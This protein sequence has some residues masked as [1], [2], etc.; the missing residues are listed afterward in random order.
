NELKDSKALI[1][2]VRGNPGGFVNNAIN[3]ASLFIEQ[4]TVV[5]IRSRIPG[6]PKSPQYETETLKLTANALVTETTDSRQPGVTSRSSGERQPNMVGDRPVVILVNGNSA[7]ASEMFTGA[8]KDNGRATVVGT[9]TFGKG[10][11]QSSLRMPNGTQLHI[12]SLRYF[13]PNGTWLGDGGNTQSHGIEPDVV[14]ESAKNLE[15][16]EDSDN[17]LKQAIEILNLKIGGG[18]H[19]FFKPLGSC[20][21]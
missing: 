12:T 15:F 8:V 13:T 7:S 2:D 11:G 3:I 1:I 17:Q 21:G 10:I 9:R 20:A 19:T 16:G 18:S 6:D 4:G 5:T 14:V